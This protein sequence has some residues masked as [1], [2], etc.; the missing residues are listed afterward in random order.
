MANGQLFASTDNCRVGVIVKAGGERAFFKI[1]DDAETN[2]DKP[3]TGLM[4]YDWFKQYRVD[5]LDP[6]EQYMVVQELNKA[7]EMLS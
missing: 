7:L 6:E 4:R 1:V 2:A 3:G 5:I